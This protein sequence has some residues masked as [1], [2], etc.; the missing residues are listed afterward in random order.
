MRPGRR[1]ARPALCVREEIETWI[2]AVRGNECR[3]IYLPVDAPLDNPL[4]IANIHSKSKGICTDYYPASPRPEIAEY[5]PLLRLVDRSVEHLHENPWVI[6]RCEPR[7]DVRPQGRRDALAALYSVVEND[8]FWDCEEISGAVQWYYR[9]QWSE[10]VDIADGTDH[11]VDIVAAHRPDKSH[12][13]ALKV[14]YLMRVCC[15]HRR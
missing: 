2:E 14:A 4:N 10:V 11:H 15:H 12:G 5:V 13:R 8:R 7:V 1:A 3:A 9:Q 6:G